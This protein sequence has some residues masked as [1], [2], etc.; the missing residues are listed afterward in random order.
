VEGTLLRSGA[1]QSSPTDLLP[2]QK[3]TQ[4]A[5]LLF[6]AVLCLVLFLVL[7]A[8]Y[9]AFV[10]RSRPAITATGTC[11]RPDPVRHHS[12]Q[13]NCTCVRHWGK[14]SYSFATNSLG[15]R[16]ESVRHVPL[17]VSKPR[18][19]L[20]G[21]SFT[22][23]MSTWPDTYVGQLTANFPQYDFLNGGIES[24]APSNYLN[25]ARQLL[26]KGVNF[27]E[28]IIFIDMSDAQDEAAFYR[29]SSPSG[30]VDGP[31][32]IV[33][34]GGLY[35]YLREFIT[36]HLLITNS[37]VDFVERQAVKHGFYHLNVG[38]GQLFDLPRSAWTYRQV[39]DSEPYE[40]GYAPLG[41]EAG[42]RKEESKMTTLWK[43]LRQRNIPI[44]VVVYPWP[45]QVAHDSVDSRQVQMWR[46]WCEG[47]CER[48]IS[49]FPEFFAVKN[50][51]PTRQAGCWYMKDFIFGDE[52]YSRAGNAFVANAV[53]K[54]LEENPPAKL[55]RST[56]REQQNPPLGLVR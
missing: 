20:L 16:D 40:I 42:L 54:S 22:E 31:A 1:V 55:N 10:L 29:D 7:D 34:N 26:D 38:H 5:L 53:D 2:E 27:D 49:V 13:A 33:H 47:K 21:D 56:G 12:L 32:Q 4:R 18:I 17:T 51:C 11:F 24:Y 41:L 48:F 14:N 37:V 23:G 50:A 6:S 19:L 46:N 8:A 36:N 35:T 39:S 15:F 43:E 52:H 28:V 25:V 30:A 3:P 45:A 9:S 44:S